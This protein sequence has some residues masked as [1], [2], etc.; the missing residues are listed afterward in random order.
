MFDFALLNSF[1][2]V[3]FNIHYDLTDITFLSDSQM[4]T[5]LGENLLKEII[6][7]RNALSSFLVWGNISMSTLSFCGS[8][9]TLCL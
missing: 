3:A 7:P 4:Y 2:F 1:L 9:V 8:A 6:N 5:V